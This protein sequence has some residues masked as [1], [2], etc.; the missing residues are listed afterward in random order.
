VVAGVL[1]EVAVSVFVFCVL[2]RRKDEVRRGI[3]ERLRGK[4]WL[5]E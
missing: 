4:G 2:E 1:T 3:E 5:V